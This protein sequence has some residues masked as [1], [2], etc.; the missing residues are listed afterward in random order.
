MT[1]SVMQRIISTVNQLWRQTP[2]VLRYGLVLSLGI[3]IIKTIEYQFFS[4]RL[5]LEFYTGLVALFFL[6]LGGAT[7]LVWR[8]HQDRQSSTQSTLP[9]EPL[10]A[11]ER[12][13]MSGLLAGKSNQQLADSHF[14]SVNTVKSHLKSIY[15][16]LDVSNRA[17][18]VE[19]IRQLNLTI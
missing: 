11:K 16:K 10:T 19:R 5:N 18:A 12:Q 9:L 17:E 7:V 2:L 8:K 1:R 15:R 14:V 6:F 13:L 3:I 4:Y